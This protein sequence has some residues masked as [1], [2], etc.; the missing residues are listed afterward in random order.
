M[1]QKNNIVVNRTAN[2]YT[3]GEIK[4]AQTIWFVL[5]GYGYLAKYFI[6]KFEPISNETV[7]IVAPE[8]L[9]KFYSNGVG[10]D[11][12]VGASWMTKES[13][14][15]EIKDY[16]NY[17][18]QLYQEIISQSNNPNVKINILGFSQGGATASRWV[19]DGIATC[20]NIILWSSAFPEDLALEKIPKNIGT[21]VL[22]GDN[23]KFIN[24]KQI[25][26]YE[27]FL[28]SSKFKCQLIKFE[29]KHDI[30]KEVLISQTNKY[31]W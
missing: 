1:I 8:G 10:Y 22:F 5:H 6:K 14:E 25:T 7:A 23:D 30:P 24:E 31:N 27:A 28:D 3:L 15:D 13:R 4:T 12:R 17:L 16:V 2:F 11:G 20:E 26:D 19:A 9:S 29:G 21:Y 18:N